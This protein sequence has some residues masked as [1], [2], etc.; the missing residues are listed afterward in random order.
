VSW[1]G[2]RWVQV[3][4]IW[5]G[6]VVALSLASILAGN[7]PK[8][9]GD[10]A[11][12]LVGAID[13]ANGQSWFDTMQY[14][15]NTPF[16]ASMHWSRLVDLPLVLLIG[17]FKPF[18]HDAAAYWAAFVWPLLVLLVVIALLADLTERV[19]GAAARLPALALLALSLPVYTEFIPG[20]VDHHNVQLALTLAMIV[21]TLRGRTSTRWA[22]VAG[23]VAAT[24][25]AVGMEV[26]PAV[27]AVLACFALYLVVEPDAVRRHVLAFAASFPIALLLHIVLVTAPQA[28]LS[29]ACDA[30]SITYVVAGIGYGVAILLAA[31]AAPLLRSWP[32]RLLSL[33]LLAVAAAA[34]VFWLFPDCRRGPYGGLDADL[35]AI[36]FPDIGEAQPIW[37]WLGDLGVLRPELALVV[38]PITG[39]A[40]LLFA[41]VSAPA[42]QR[43]RWL[44]LVTFCAALFMVF[45]LQVRGFRLLTIPLLPASA[46]LVVY[47]LDWFRKRQTVVA[48]AVTVVAV[49]ALSGAVQWTLFE[50][51]FSQTEAPQGK[52][53]LDASW[54]ACLDRDAYAPLAQ[55][56]QGRMMSFL[57]IGPQ[58]LLETPHSIVSAGYHR[59]AAGLRDMLRFFGKGEAEALAV[60]RERGLDYLVF[61]KGL[62]A[63]HGLAGTAEFEGSS[64]SWLTRLSAPDAPLQIY[65]ID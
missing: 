6:L 49:S 24:G 23:L 55:L 54:D 36:L 50:R 22:V 63:N 62:P 57:L 47:L 25:L 18:A 65:A 52:E 53:I 32:A 16:G 3:V 2:N 7:A 56:P 30:L 59:N 26:L 40:V 44:V 43:W 8:V 33:F 37:V 20:R 27:L 48:A 46:W 29:P 45:C 12:R 64:W 35:V 21:A 10:D 58:L 61:C 34:V 1:T 4:V 14:R 17:L 11:M 31:F 13:L 19:A 9:T 39:M 5:L 38:T 28:W 15:D 41:T 60:A 42:H 51:L